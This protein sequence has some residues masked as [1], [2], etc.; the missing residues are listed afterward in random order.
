MNKNSFIYSGL[1]LVSLVF[2][3]VLLNRGVISGLT[4]DSDVSLS[5]AT[6]THLLGQT[7]VFNGS[8][9][10][11]TEEVAS[12][13]SVTL[14]NTSG[15]QGLEVVLPTAD[16]FDQ[17][18]DLSSEVSGTLLVKIDFDGVTGEVWGST[19]PFSTLPGSGTFKGSTA[20]G[21]IDYEIH[22]TPP[23]FLDPPPTFT[24]I[25]LTDTEF[26]IPVIAPPATTTGT[27]LP[28][29]DLVFQIP[30]VGAP[31]ITA[32][33]SVTSTVD[34][35]LVT[36]STNA[37]TTTPSLPGLTY[38]N[39]GFDVPTVSVPTSSVNSFP[40]SSAGFDIQIP[41]AATGPAGVPNLPEFAL[42]FP[43]GS[44][45]RGIA[46]D[47]S[48]FWVISDNTGPGGAD[49]INRFTS[50]GVATSTPIVG[51]SDQLEGIAYLNGFLWLVDNSEHC[52]NPINPFCDFRGHH[53]FKVDPN[54][55][56]PTGDPVAWS[57]LDTIFGPDRFDSLGGITAEGSGATGTLWLAAEGGFSFYNISQTGSE[58]SSTSPKGFVAGMD[59]LALS[60][61]FLYTGKDNVVTQWTKTG[62]KVQDFNAV[63]TGPMSPI[64][65]IKGMTFKVVSSKQVLFAGSADGAVYKGFFAPT[66]T[67]NPVGITLSPSTALVGRALWTVVDGTPKDKIL[68]ANPDTGALL[69]FGTSGAAD[70]PSN[71][72]EGITYFNSS[73]WLIANEPDPF[74]GGPFG[75]G[76]AKL[77]K[78]NPQ[79]GSLTTTY[80]LSAYVNED[81][82]GITNNGTNL[83]VHSKSNFN[84]VW[85]IDS[86]TGNKV[87]DNDPCCPG[88][89]FIGA[90]G[91]AYHSGRKQYFVGTDNIIAQYDESRRFEQESPISQS[92]GTPPTNIQGLA[93]EENTLFIAHTGSGKISKSF[94]ATTISTTPRGIAYTSATT[95][96]FGTALYILVDG[97]PK[98]KILKVD[99]ATGSIITT[100]SF[101]TN[102]VADAPSNSTEGITFLSDFLWVIG[103]EGSGFDSQSKLYKI[104]PTTGALVLS[105][106]LN[107]PPANIGD[108]LGGITN[109]GTKLFVSVK[110]FNDVIKL[111]LN[112]TL[113]GIEDSE[114]VF[115]P[116]QNTFG[117]RALARHASRNQFL[118]ARDNS[119]VTV[120][121]TFQNLLSEQTLQL[122]GGAFTGSV[123]G[124]VFDQDVLYAAY[125]DGGTGKV[126]LGALKDSATNSPRGLAFSPTGSSLSGSSIGQALWVLV[127][128]DPTDKILKLD[129]ATGQLITTSNFPSSTNDVG[130]AS[131]PSGTTEGMTYLGGYLWI[132]SNE[133]SPFGPSGP[134]LYKV[135][136]TD[137]S[138][139]QTYDLSSFLFD[140]VAGITNDGTNLQLFNAQW[141]QMIV[142]ATDGTK[143]SDVPFG[144]AS[145]QGAEGAARRIGTDQVI[146][147]R[148]S[149]IAQYAVQGGGLIL[150]GEFTTALTGI[151]GLTFDVGA[152]GDVTDDVL[153]IAHKG[154]GKVS[155]AGIP[156]DITNKPRGLAYD[157]TA[158]ELYILVDGKGEA[159]DHIVVVDPDDASDPPTPIRAF[160]LPLRGESTSITY[161]NGALYVGIEEFSHGGGGSPPVKILKLNPTTGA[162]IA[163]I[164][165]GFLS[166]K[167]L[168]M[169][170]DGTSLIVAPEWGGPHVEYVD[171]D[172]AFK[173]KDVYFFD[174]SGPG[175]FEEGF[176]GLAYST[177]T[178]AFY[179]V[180]GN[181]VWRV[182]GNGEL[183]D[184]FATALTGIQGAVF[185]D[186]KIFLADGGAKSIRS[187][188]VPLPPVTITQNP[189]AMATDGTNLFLA[190]DAEPDDKILKLSANPGALIGGFGDGGAADSPGTETDGLAILG[191][192][193]YAVTNDVESVPT[194]QGP[195][196]QALPLIHRID[197][198]TGDHLMKFP[199]LVSNGGVLEI[200]KDE[201]GSLASDGNNLYAG[202]K[203]TG[204]IT[205]RWFEIDVNNL[206]SFN[207]FG[208]QIFA[209][210]AQ[211]IDEFAGQ[212][213]PMDG[214]EAFEITM[215]AEFPANSQLIATG[216]VSGSGNAD[217]IAR[218]NK[219]SGA[220]FRETSSGATDGQFKLTG[221]DIKGMAYIAT[222]TSTT[223]ARKLYLAD[224]TSNSVLSTK[225][226]ENTGV[227]V[228]VVGSYV[229][230]LEV[231]LDSTTLG[232]D[233]TAYTIVRNP[234]VVVELQNPTNGFVITQATSTISGRVNDPSVGDV[235]IGITLPFAKFVDD[236]V[237]RGTSPAVLGVGTDGGGAQWHIACSD[238]A[239]G[240]PGP[241]RASSPTCSWRYGIPD[242]PNFDTGTRTKGSLATKDPIS[243]SQDSKL[244]FFTGYDTEVASDA[245]IKLVEVAT[246]TTDLQGNDVVGQ[247]QPVL[248]IVGAGGSGA[249]WPANAHAS[250]HFV[251]LSP[252]FINPNLVPIE[253]DLAPFAGQRI[254]IRFRFDSIDPHANN[255]EGWYVDDIQVSGAG[256]KT[257]TVTT[258]PIDE[259]DGGTRYFRAFSIPSFTLSEGQN[260]I[261][262]EAQQPYS[263]Y[264]QALVT[265]TG[266]VDTTL[267]QI[268]L[269]NVPAATN[270]LSHTLRGTIQDLTLQSLEII[271]TVPDG[272]TSTIFAISSVPEGGTFNVGVTLPEGANTFNAQ[273]ID[274][275][276][277]IGA[278][279]LQTIADFTNPTAQVQVVPVTS[280]GEAVVGDQFFVLAAASDNLSGVASV[281]DVQSG[282]SLI[283]ISSAPPILVEMHGLNTVNGSSTTHVLLSTVQSG[284]PVG[285]NSISLTVTDSAGNQS[286]TSADVLSVVSARTNR[287]YFLF[288]GINF[289]G[290][291]LIPDDGNPATTD[292]ASLDRLMA[293]DVTD[294]VNPAFVTHLA[295]TTVTLGNVV[296]STFAFE[297]GT[298]LVHTPG[299]G[300]ADTLTSMAP[301]QGMI[302]KT[303]E[304]LS[305]TSTTIDIFRQVD[306]EGFTAQQA[307]PIRINIQGLFIKTGDI[308]PPEKT[309]SPGYNLVAPHI[310]DDTTFDVVYRGALIPDQLAVS[311]ITFERRVDADDEGSSGI[312]AEIFEGFVVQ[313][314]GELLKP[315][316]SYWTYIVSGSPTITP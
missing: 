61:D 79:N 123:Q 9:V 99:P 120:D 101:G 47:G 95:T 295:T 263:P 172:T 230:R 184:E 276:G 112:G 180:K 56:P 203:G 269:F 38:T 24:L 240:F 17:F 80:D 152:S 291:A 32:L 151:E 220:M 187:A 183:I 177:T 247:F 30:T 145:F 171:F 209:P 231:E 129:P 26:V 114:R 272:S 88:P 55:P 10:F 179:P 1:L 162:Q 309:M 266:F 217:T 113:T 202:V 115:F 67:T 73:L 50:A 273:A 69:T 2:A 14:K 244:K 258:T 249:P 150:I 229:T 28:A 312:G 285:L 22:W 119:L 302:I 246:V 60:G 311:A 199:I 121:S 90:K 86:A 210:V 182:E 43:G 156:S 68:K 293:Q 303:N 308:T 12:L 298:F 292:D 296:D 281:T 52:G 253:F 21:T 218:F 96:S 243:A 174:P 11:D 19:L 48:D 78:V 307:V 134:K 122:D 144:G 105:I 57:G 141:D 117:S 53:I 236:A 271:Q 35:P 140:N 166:G 5:T 128:G 290:L 299:T 158:N 206:Q 193:L 316:L 264:L 212:L 185:V 305:T 277:L 191:G 59:S 25:P 224:D 205:R 257:V 204:G 139:V 235:T 197:P 228:T 20:G 245:D 148:G 282:D 233:T 64:T 288:P 160:S 215:G 118:S 214:F 124:M 71:N 221:K 72:I 42:H 188:L 40:D 108:P 8:L 241:A 278:A 62:D 261:G 238:S 262:A 164:T 31:D 237:D 85:V 196:Q 200:L 116:S 159:P 223:T 181:K 87:S 23:V 227:E 131:A 89:S 287:N 167:P 15:P 125:T 18:V 213:L 103:S 226:P 314:L 300:A 153:Y 91:I 127:D 163:S 279:S 84:Q 173:E 41:T 77:Y 111:T 265:V 313:S 74:G 251:E 130:Y 97:A 283:P 301:F 149:K 16:T 70:A 280:Q 107:G 100:G 248:Q 255:G 297:A 216:D 135:K 110:P 190:I 94:L 275:G 136:A 310:L 76:I 306:V 104:N 254:K 4:T 132:I 39:G 138:L 286:T 49:V 36:I 58:V 304:D 192:F 211:P 83:V 178:P 252:L 256:I 146:T 201:L 82:G 147:A 33:P 315:V 126:A 239:P 219:D 102:G 170:S 294:Q 198:A 161:L 34:I 3:A 142:V 194:P 46:T 270:D 157:P 250:F 98:D 65:G 289:M 207:L 267:P 225:L 154:S 137:G 63:L 222:T 208:E 66:V 155:K 75:G 143:D 44:P 92:G 186:N 93:F 260:T 176:Q 268:T 284:T 195:V 274:G 29:S 133:T 13:V 45:T 51:P 232:N 242:G 54:T 168:G 189:R 259:T 81:V 165:V 37:A 7:I 106:N 27:K 6:S 169:A 175:F 234:E 109:N